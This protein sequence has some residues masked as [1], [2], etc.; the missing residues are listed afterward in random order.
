MQFASY[1]TPSL[2]WHHPYQYLLGDATMP[3]CLH[4]WLLEHAPRWVRFECHKRLWLPSMDT[5]WF[6]DEMVRG[7]IQQ[8]PFGSPELLHL[9]LTLVFHE[10]NL[11]R[12]MFFLFVI[13]ILSTSSWISKLTKIQKCNHLMEKL[14][15]VNI[16]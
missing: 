15:P 16:C 13:L 3:F 5:N 8:Y 2:S 6:S 11:L 12:I 9:V 4:G 1:L 14:V 7:L 10:C